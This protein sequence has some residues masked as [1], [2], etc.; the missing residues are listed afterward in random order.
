VG[1]LFLAV[2]TEILILT[3]EGTVDFGRNF[4]VN[5]ARA[6]WEACSPTWDLDTNST[7]AQGPVKTSDNL[8]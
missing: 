8:V 6:S 1:Q 7:F 2:S 5:I 3:T 4:G